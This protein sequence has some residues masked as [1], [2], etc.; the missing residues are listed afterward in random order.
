MS[1]QTAEY[2]TEPMP[3]AVNR[4][5]ILYWHDRTTKKTERKDSNIPKNCYV[6]L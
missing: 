5:C 4:F 2:Y 3:Y 6:L 1:E